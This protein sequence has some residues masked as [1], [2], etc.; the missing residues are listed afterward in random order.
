MK[1][2]R[3][4]S[5]NFPTDSFKFPTEEIT[6]APEFNFAPKFPPKW[7]FSTQILH[8]WTKI[9]FSDSPTFKRDNYPPPSCPPCYETTK[10]ERNVEKQLKHATSGGQEC[11]FH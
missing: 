4:G 9:K 1:L 5:C 11:R 8:F 10:H 3:A 6:G 2:G 7:V